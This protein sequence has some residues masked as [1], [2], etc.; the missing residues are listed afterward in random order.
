LNPLKVWFERKKS[1]NL[2]N[3]ANL[4]AAGPT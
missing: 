4:Q 2:H 3:F 1:M